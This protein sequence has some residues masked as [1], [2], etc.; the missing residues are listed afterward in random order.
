[1]TVTFKY[2][3][4][5]VTL[6]FSIMTLTLNY[7]LELERQESQSGLAAVDHGKVT[8]DEQTDGKADERTIG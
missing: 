5:H 3:L 2:N 4:R 8:D 6:T 1:M 7:N